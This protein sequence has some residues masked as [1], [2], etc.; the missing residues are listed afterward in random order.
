MAARARE[1]WHV[2]WTDAEIR[3]APRKAGFE[4]VRHFDGFDVR[5]K[6]PG[7]NRGTDSYYLARKARASKK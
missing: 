2:C 7:I 6:M 1:V 4:F 5:P 3:Q